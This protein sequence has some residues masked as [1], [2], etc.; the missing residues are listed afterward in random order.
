MTKE[1]ILNNLH[2]EGKDI[3]VWEYILEDGEELTLNELKKLNEMGSIYHSEQTGVDYED[4]DEDD[5]VV[6]Y[7]NIYYFSQ[8]SSDIHQNQM[9]L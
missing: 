9:P 5:I 6:K 7:M 8:A 4:E 3:N 1:E 2:Q